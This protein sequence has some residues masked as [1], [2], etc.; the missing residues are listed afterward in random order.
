[1][2]ILLEKDRE[3]E[4]K[5]EIESKCNYSCHK[6]EAEIHSCL[7]NSLQSAFLEGSGKINEG[8]ITTRPKIPSLKIVNICERPSL[9][10]LKKCI[11]YNLL[12]RGRVELRFV[13]I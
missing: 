2:S 3:R 13:V 10:R 12:W 1:M 4:R 11:K 7:E 6:L 5:R 9:P 8:P